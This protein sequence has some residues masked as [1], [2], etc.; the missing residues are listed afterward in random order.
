MRIAHSGLYHTRGLKSHLLGLVVA[1]L[2]TVGQVESGELLTQSLLGAGDG[3]QRCVQLNVTGALG[4][5]S[6]CKHSGLHPHR[7][8][9]QPICSETA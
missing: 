8:Q 4:E 1:V 2:V 3:I 5:N 6:R 9:T 7:K